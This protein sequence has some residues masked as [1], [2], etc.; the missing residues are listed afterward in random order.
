[1][2]LQSTPVTDRR[3]IQSRAISSRRRVGL[4]ELILVYVII[5]LLAVTGALILGDHGVAPPLPC[6]D[7]VGACAAF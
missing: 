7:Y 5:N 6:G 1:M 4:R 2:L 3:H